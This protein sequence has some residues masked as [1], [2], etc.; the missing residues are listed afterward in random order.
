[1]SV[2]GDRVRHEGLSA[3]GLTNLLTSQRDNIATSIPGALG[4]LIGF[5]S[6]RPGALVGET[7]TPHTARRRS[8]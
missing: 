2:L 7:Y 4:R 8:P 6:V 5:G 3:S 1:M